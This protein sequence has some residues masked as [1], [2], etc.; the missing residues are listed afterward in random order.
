MLYSSARVTPPEADDRIEYCAD[1]VGEW[2]A[3]DD[4]HRRSDPA[5]AAEKTARGRSHIAVR[6]RFPFG[7]DYVSHP[8]LGLAW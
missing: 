2:V 1:R 6:R 7:D 5:P 4:R 8:D 3:V